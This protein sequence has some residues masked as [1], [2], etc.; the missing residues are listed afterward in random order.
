MVFTGKGNS[1]HDV[2]RTPMQHVQKHSQVVLLR[3]PTPSPQP[4]TSS[5]SPSLPDSIQSPYICWASAAIA[6]KWCDLGGL[7]APW[8]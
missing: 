2:S 4:A 6:P 8:A 1:M 5:V 7:L 3:R